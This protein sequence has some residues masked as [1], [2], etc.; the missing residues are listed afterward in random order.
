MLA[1]H[2]A[3]NPLLLT[4]CLP[5]VGQHCIVAAWA[6]QSTPVCSYSSQLGFFLFIR[7]I[8]L[9]VCAAEK[10]NKLT[11]Q[12]DK[13][14][15]SNTLN[16]DQTLGIPW[17]LGLK[18]KPVNLSILY[19]VSGHIHCT[20]PSQ[21]CTCSRRSHCLTLL[22]WEWIAWVT[23]KAALSTVIRNRKHLVVLPGQAILQSQLCFLGH[24]LH[25]SSEFGSRIFF[26]RTAFL[27]SRGHCRYVCTYLP[28]VYAHTQK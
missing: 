23:P 12:T 18:C 28:L 22:S 20:D 21:S 6:L 8:T 13:K 2:R 5:S 25:L 3:F 15:Q 27:F 24:R 19:I 11:K 17:F 16:R 9:R 14:N 7:G 4:P 1:V 26:C 10:T